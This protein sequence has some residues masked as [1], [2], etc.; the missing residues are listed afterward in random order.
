M[1]LPE[2]LL[3]DCQRALEQGFSLGV[4][5]LPLIQRRQIVQFRRDL[6]AIEAIG[7]LQ[8]RKRALVERFGL[9]VLTLTAIEQRQIV[10]RAGEVA[11]DRTNGFLEVG[12]LPLRQGDRLGVFSGPAEFGNSGTE[13][14]TVAFLRKA[15]SAETGTRDQPQPHGQSQP[16]AGC[17]AGFVSHSTAAA[18]LPWIV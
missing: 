16:I 4:T 15:R 7:F 13:R 12:D 3:A 9:A 17:H 8:D 14:G 6:D 18:A 11:I 10:Q 5:T 2:R 1:G